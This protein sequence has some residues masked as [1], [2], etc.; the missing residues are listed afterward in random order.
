LEYDITSFFKKYI[1]IP[2]SNVWWKIKRTSPRWGEFVI[3]AKSMIEKRHRSQT[4]FRV[5]LGISIE[6]Q[7]H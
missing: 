4:C 2:I 5:G 3:R 7:Y 1:V 6:K